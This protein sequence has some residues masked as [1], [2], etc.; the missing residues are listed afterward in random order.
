MLSIVNRDDGIDR[1]SLTCQRFREF[2]DEIFSSD[3]VWSK[4]Y[5]VYNFNIRI[6]GK[7]KI[8]DFGW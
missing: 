7:F 8:C 5:Q 6:R 3:E 4:R 2:Y 1:L